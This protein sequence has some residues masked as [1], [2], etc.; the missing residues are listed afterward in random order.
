MNGLSDLHLRRLDLTVYSAKKTPGHNLP[1]ELVDKITGFYAR[2]HESLRIFSL[3]GPVFA[4]SCR[5]YLFRDIVLRPRHFAL[6][7]KHILTSFDD[8]PE[9]QQSI[10][11]LTISSRTH[12]GPASGL[13]DERRLALDPDFLE[14]LLQ[15]LSRLH[16]V[17][18]EG[19]TIEPQSGTATDFLPYCRS[20]SQLRSLSISPSS[21][22][23]PFIDVFRIMAFFRRVAV[24]TLQFGSAIGSGVEPDPYGTD[25]HDHLARHRRYRKY[26]DAP[27]YELLRGWR[28]GKIHVC[29]SGQ[30]PFMHGIQATVAGLLSIDVGKA[31]QLPR[32][33]FEFL[34]IWAVEPPQ[35]RTDLA[36]KLVNLQLRM[37][38]KHTGSERGASQACERF[39]RI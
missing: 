1:R 20:R 17:V 19:C 38:R 7:P 35:F 30:A 15:K 25:R 23:L 9:L 31:V 4:S 6:G 32:W 22:V 14:A 10:I 26:V 29:A 8:I 13:S 3:I 16:D 21:E 33:G 2:D 39:S 36:Q 37:G 27:Q 28:I 18:L 12:K 5:T 11:S 24:D 34:I